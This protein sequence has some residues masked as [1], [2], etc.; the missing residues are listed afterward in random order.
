MRRREFASF[1]GVLAGTWPVV[2]GAQQAKSPLVGFLRPSSAQ[3]AE[4]M[5]AALRQGL[6]ELGFVEN[7]NVRIEFRWAEDKYDRLAALARELVRLPADVIVA[8]AFTAARA[9]KAATSTIPIVFTSAGDPVRQG[10]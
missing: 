6:T 4:P 1:L 3:E 7:R 10:L 2:A 9:A 5:V 8:G